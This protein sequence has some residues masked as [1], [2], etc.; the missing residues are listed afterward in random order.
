VNFTGK[1]DLTAERQRQLT[2]L[3]AA[4]GQAQQAARTLCNSRDGDN[5]VKLL[6]DQL[7]A[8]RLEVEQLRRENGMGPFEEIDPKWTGFLRWAPIPEY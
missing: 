6:S 7:E 1:P 8:L 4:V 5:G 2:E 3:L